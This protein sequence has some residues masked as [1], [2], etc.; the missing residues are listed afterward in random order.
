VAD[1]SRM[2]D[3]EAFAKEIAERHNCIDVLINNAGVFRTPDPV[4]RDGLDGR[5]AV[6]AIAPFLLTRRLLPL[7]RS[8][9]RV[10]NVSSAAQAPVDLEALT[11]K[12]KSASTPHGLPRKS[13]AESVARNVSIA[14]LTVTVKTLHKSACNPPM[15]FD[16]DIFST[17]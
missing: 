8:G 12:V 7:L 16:G 11:I 6:N 2:A 17:I 4:T 5:F 15:T 10:I 3:V 1:L 13:V 14:G 9:G